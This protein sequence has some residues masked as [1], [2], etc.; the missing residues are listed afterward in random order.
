MKVI[1]Y[2]TSRNALNIVH[3]HGGPLRETGSEWP[4][5]GFTA[6][7]LTEKE[8]TLDESEGYVTPEA[9]PDVVE[10]DEAH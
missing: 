5:D 2:P 6:R 3:P 1:V 10:P 9:T 8:A 7:M 4:N